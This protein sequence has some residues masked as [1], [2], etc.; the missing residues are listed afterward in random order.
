V[1]RSATDG[2]AQI[3]WREL[4]T[5]PELQAKLEPWSP[6]YP[7]AQNADGTIAGQFDPFQQQAPNQPDPEQVAAD[8]AAA[9]PPGSR[10]LTDQ[11]SYDVRFRVADGSGSRGGATGDSVSDSGRSVAAD[12]R[13]SDWAEP[14][15][16]GLVD[17]VEG[18]L[19][20]SPGDVAV[21]PAF[22]RHT[23]IEVGD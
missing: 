2:P 10:L 20:D 7:I 11:I 6:G 16:A 4:G 22:V 14:S 3:V 21:S 19:P 15:L 13:Q 17:L 12:L 9:V 1:A 5:H 18:T 8:L 23:G